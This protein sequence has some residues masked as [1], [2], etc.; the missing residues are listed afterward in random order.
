M[1]LLVVDGFSS[2]DQFE[3]SSNGNSLGITS[4]PST[5]ANCVSDI[6]CALGDTRFSQGSFPLSPG[7]N[8]LTG[9]TVLSPLGGGA[10]FFTISS[11][12]A[13]AQAPSLSGAM[14]AGQVNQ[15]YSFTPTLGPAGVSMP[16][17]FAVIGTLPPG[18]ALSPTTGTVSGTPTQAG[19]FTFTLLATNAVGSD[20]LPLSWVVAPLA[21]PVPTL[22]TWGLI[23][24]SLMAVGLGRRRLNAQGPRG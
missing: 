14:A 20:D 6:T 24:L 1:R 16:V 10:G 2:G 19:T 8:T 17:T 11:Q 22:Q 9:T 15:A 3:L 7:T 23:A 4:V 5:G 18:M 12:P 21:V 13:Q